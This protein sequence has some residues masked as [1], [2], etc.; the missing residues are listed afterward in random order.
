MYTRSPPTAGIFIVLPVWKEF[1]C[2]CQ[3]V[4]PD[5]AAGP[6]CRQHRPDHFHWRLWRTGSDCCC[7]SAR[8]MPCAA[9]AADQGSGSS[10]PEPSCAD[11]NQCSEFFLGHACLDYPA[12]VGRVI[13]FS[14]GKNL[15]SA[16][17]WL[18]RDKRRKPHKQGLGKALP[19]KIPA[20]AK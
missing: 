8:D 15:L 13:S 6:P 12:T 3:S 10:R 16:A 9:V 14:H 20:G 17:A 11:R 4:H 1:A 18:R 7:T 5:A 19:N 2:Q